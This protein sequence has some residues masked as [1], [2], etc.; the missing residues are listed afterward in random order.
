MTQAG[1]GNC[2]SH[3]RETDGGQRSSNNAQ[4]S[5]SDDEISSGFMNP[6]RL[7]ASVKSP[8]AAQPAAASV[9]IP[10]TLHAHADTSTSPC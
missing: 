5:A 8:A 7:S 6:D 2:G 1:N 9:C 3:Q 4:S 10:P